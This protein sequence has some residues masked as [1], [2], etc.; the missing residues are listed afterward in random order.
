ML[1]FAGYVRRFRSYIQISL[2]QFHP[3]TMSGEHQATKSAYFWVFLC[4]LSADKVLLRRNATFLS[5]SRYCN[6]QMASRKS[7]LC[8]WSTDATGRVDFSCIT[9]FVL[10]LFLC[11]CVYFGVVSLTTCSLLRPFLRWKLP[12]WSMYRRF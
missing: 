10:Y 9:C 2:M 5:C 4:L 3:A 12:T 6:W 11:T 8:F 1:F 7:V